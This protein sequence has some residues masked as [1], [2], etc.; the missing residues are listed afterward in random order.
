MGPPE[1]KIAQRGGRNG[2]FARKID[3]L[4]LFVSES[5]YIDGA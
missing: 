5:G 1:W 4:L 3:F 2:L